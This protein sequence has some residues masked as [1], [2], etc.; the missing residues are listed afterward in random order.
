[1]TWLGPVN[2][3]P[4]KRTTWENSRRKS[5]AAY[6]ASQLTPTVPRPNL[7]ENNLQC[8]SEIKLCCRNVFDSTFFRGVCGTPSF[9]FAT[10]LIVCCARLSIACCMPCLLVVG[11]Y[12]YLVAV[13]PRGEPAQGLGW[14]FIGASG[15]KMVLTW[16]ATERVISTLEKNSQPRSF[17][18]SWKF[19]VNLESASPHHFTKPNSNPTQ[20]LVWTLVGFSLVENTQPG[21]KTQTKFNSTHSVW[22][23][24]N[25]TSTYSK[26][27]HVIQYSI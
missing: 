25:V 10:I 22:H 27:E 5:V 14:K 8:I 12:H 15:L 18:L 1:M 19:T 11:T 16:A 4:D 21:L 9:A 2:D 3:S 24:L 26:L 17:S 6:S 23:P 20:L 13:W 7:Y